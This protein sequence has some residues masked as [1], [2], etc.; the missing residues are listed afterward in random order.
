MIYYYR[1]SY[2]RDKLALDIG[3]PAFRFGAGFF[4]T[5]FY[6]GGT[7]CHLDAHTARITESLETYQIPYETIDFA[8]VITRVL[9]QNKLTGRPSRINIY[10]LIETAPAP[11]SPLIAARPCSVDENRTFRLSVSP[12]HHLSHLCAHKT[13]NYM[14]HYLALADARRREFDDALLTDRTGRV[15]ETCTASLVFSDGTYLFTPAA[16]ER[17]PG[18][19][20]KIAGSVL[21]VSEIAIRLKDLPEFRHAYVL[22]SIIGMKPVILIDDVA[23][24]A[25]RGTCLPVTRRIL[26]L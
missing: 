2:I 18:I 19:A 1:G 3:G 15:L 10:Y 23:Y 25:D 9:R 21:S 14:H 11:A 5:L 8:Q 22:N 6:N 17:L 7:I 13:T 20:L 4:E 24:P 26:A 12:R 16:E